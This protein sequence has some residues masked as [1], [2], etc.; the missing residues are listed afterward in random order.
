MTNCELCGDGVDT[1]ANPEEFRVL[2]TDCFVTEH[3]PHCGGEQ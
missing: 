3:H 2:C 1:N